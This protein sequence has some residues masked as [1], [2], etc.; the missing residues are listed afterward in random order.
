[1]KEDF[2]YSRRQYEKTTLQPAR[3]NARR[4]AIICAVF[5]AALVAIYVNERFFNWW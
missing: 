4:E 2:S 3:R 1:M 5:V